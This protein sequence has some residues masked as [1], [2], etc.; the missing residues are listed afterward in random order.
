MHSIGQEYC[1]TNWIYDSVGNKC[2]WAASATSTWTAAQTT[3]LTASNNAGKLVE[4]RDTASG[5]FIKN[6]FPAGVY[7][8]DQIYVKA[9]VSEILIRKVF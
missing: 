7:Y 3:C 5:D 9:I 8:A 6:S 1:L 2:Y 4:P